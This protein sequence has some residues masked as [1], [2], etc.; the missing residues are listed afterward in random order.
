MLLRRHAFAPFQCCGQK[1]TCGK[2]VPAGAAVWHA[3][4][5]GWKLTQ[6]GGG[7]KGGQAGGGGGGL[8]PTPEGDALDGAARVDAGLHAGV[9][10]LVVVGLLL[11]GLALAAG[12][13][14]ACTQ[15]FH[16]SGPCTRL[17]FR[18]ALLS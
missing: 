13:V 4:A 6:G 14:S 17:L 11:L 12:L 10:L 2:Y 9:H 5:V 1:R 7:I 18:E 3:C 15:A 16:T 8:S